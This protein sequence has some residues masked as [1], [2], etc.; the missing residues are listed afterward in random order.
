MARQST[1]PAID[2]TAPVTQPA[3][4]EPPVRAQ[5]ETPIAESY[6][7]RQVSAKLQAYEQR[8]KF[9]ELTRRLD[10]TGATLQDGTIVGNRINRVLLWLI[11]N[12]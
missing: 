3:W 1:L 10:D 5:A 11:E 12:S 8:V 9:R 4:Q 7:A 2:G 6:M